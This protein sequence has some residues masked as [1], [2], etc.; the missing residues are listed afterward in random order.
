[1]SELDSTLVVINTSPVCILGGWLLSN[2]LRLEFCGEV[3]AGSADLSVC[4]H[5][6][7][8]NKSGGGATWISFV[9]LDK[10]NSGSEI[11][12]K[13][14]VIQGQKKEGKKIK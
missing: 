1:M 4:F 6:T 12:Q 11:Q 10:R 2:L 9:K 8:T 7:P 3:A 13:V 14:S 5:S